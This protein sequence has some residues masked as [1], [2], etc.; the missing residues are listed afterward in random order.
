M[1]TR[2]HAIRPSRCKYHVSKKKQKLQIYTLQQL[3]IIYKYA[4]AAIK[5]RVNSNLAA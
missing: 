5:E 4:H 1:H 2:E 3:K